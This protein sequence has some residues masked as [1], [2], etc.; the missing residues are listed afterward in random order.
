MHIA[1]SGLP[2]NT[3]HGNKWVGLDVYE[4]KCESFSRSERF[5]LFVRSAT[6]FVF[7]NS[8]CSRP[9]ASFISQSLKAFTI[10]SHA[11]AS[12][13]MTSEHR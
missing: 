5:I 11:A 10:V 12:N 8:R 7:S 6:S 9:L 1:E 13:K 4:G 2:E 3:F